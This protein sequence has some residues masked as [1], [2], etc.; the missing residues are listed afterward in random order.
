M[1]CGWEGNRRSDVALDMRHRLK[2]RFI[3]LR[4]HGLDKEMSSAVEHGPFTF[5]IFMFTPVQY[6][7]TIY[8]P[9]AALLIHITRRSEDSLAYIRRFRCAVL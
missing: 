8:S 1:P 7:I 2:C 4:A 6:N 5:T 9:N 3:H